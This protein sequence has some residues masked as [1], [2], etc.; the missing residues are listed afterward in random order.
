MV[1]HR[2]YQV[3][4]FGGAPFLGNPVAVVLTA[5]AMSHDTMQRIAQWTNLSETTFLVAPKDPQ[6][7]YG[8]RIFTTNQELPFA[9]HPTLGSA[10][11]WLQAGGTTGSPDR[12]VQE[13]GIGLVTLRPTNGRLEFNAPPLLRSGPPDAGF[14]ARVIEMLRADRRRIVDMEWVD[15][16]PGWVGVLLD[17]AASVLA[18]EPGIVDCPIGA[19]GPHP[20]GAPAQFEVRAFF[21]SNGTTLED[22]VTG[23][24]NASL[25]L[26]LLG[27]GRAKSPY[28]AS[29]GTAIGRFGRIHVQRDDDGATWIGGTTKTLIEGV[30]EPVE[31]P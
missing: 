9:G 31:P 20:E 2:F 15:N 17:S 8:V 10:H 24:L 23:S 11:A 26:W 22:P 27:S 1:T 14:Q 13:C 6:A 16:G 18:L 19:V 21:P 3:D 5:D 30:I 28:I 29:Q 7:D 4:V 25:A 12:I